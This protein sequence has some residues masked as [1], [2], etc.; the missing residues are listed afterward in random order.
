MQRYWAVLYCVIAQ[1]GV[2]SLRAHKLFYAHQ[3]VGCDAHLSPFFGLG[4]PVVSDEMHLS[5]FMALIHIIPF[6]SFF[7]FAAFH[8]CKV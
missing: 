8:R 5:S 1:S 3:L 2:R 4:I 6:F 7:F